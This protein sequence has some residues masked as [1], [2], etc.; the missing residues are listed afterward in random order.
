MDEI[1]KKKMVLPSKSK[2][3]S[4]AEKLVYNVLIN[5]SV[6]SDDLAQIAKLCKLLTFR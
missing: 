3:L 6:K 4:G 2:Q 1:T 5:Q